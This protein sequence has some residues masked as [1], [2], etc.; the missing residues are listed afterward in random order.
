M[1]RDTEKQSNL[2][3]TI[4][5]GTDLDVTAGACLM[6]VA[7][8]K[9]IVGQSIERSNATDGEWPAIIWRTGHDRVAG[10]RCEGLEFETASFYGKEIS[11]HGGRA[12]WEAA[13][14]ENTYSWARRM[15]LA[16]AT[17]LA[18]A[19]VV[20]TKTDDYQLRGLAKPE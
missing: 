4:A 9:M 14:Y 1:Q 18:I 10:V 13:T 8:A 3:A 7:G 12:N 19:R 15:A 16:S 2:V 11:E 20:D 6:T 5:L 17:A